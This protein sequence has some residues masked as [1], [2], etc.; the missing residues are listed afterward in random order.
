MNAPDEKIQDIVQVLPGMKSPT[1][2]PLALKGW[3]SIHT[4]LTEDEFWQHIEE[5][6]SVGAEDILVLPVEK[7]VV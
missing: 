3:S 6:K 2:L 1:V 7:M 4:V 5:I